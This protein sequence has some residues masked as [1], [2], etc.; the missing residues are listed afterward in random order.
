MKSKNKKNVK[1]L[2]S[3]KIADALTLKPRADIEDDTVFGT[4]PRTVTWAELGSSDSEDEATISDFRKRNV[5]L[6]SDISKKYEGKVVTRKNFENSEE[7]S[8]ISES[9]DSSNK[10]QNVSQKMSMDSS[11]DSEKEQ[12]VPKSMELKESDSEDFDSDAESDDYS[13]TKFGK[14]SQ[15]ATDNEES[16]DVEE[17]DDDGDAYD[18]SQ[19]DEPMKEDFEHVKKQNISEEAKKGIC[20]RNQLLVWE[21]LLEMRIHLQR[22]MNTANQM[23]MPDTY[24]TLKDQTEFIE[25][26]N[27]TKLNV[28]N[29][30][31]K[32][33]FIAIYLILL[34]G[35]S[36][37]CHLGLGFCQHIM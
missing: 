8:D 16:E 29:V 35:I 14:K 3:D 10:D 9:E 6:L 4:K 18:I 2:L 27:A 21:N 37:V 22:C 34:L 19:M 1:Q 32:Y 15:D 12:G 17:N 23:P 11:D 33:V 31:D 5:N 20:V 30:L 36:I 13:I 28:A 25:E 24:A 26:A 7:E